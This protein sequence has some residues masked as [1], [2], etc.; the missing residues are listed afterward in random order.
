MS[1]TPD[2]KIDKEFKE[3]NKLL[4]DFD[5]ISSS[6]A[7]RLEEVNTEIQNASDHLFNLMDPRPKSV[8][9][10]IS[11]ASLDNKEKNKERNVH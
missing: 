11:N 3:T 10:P 8:L 5:K 9:K 1:K 2:K 4:E 7:T 6:R